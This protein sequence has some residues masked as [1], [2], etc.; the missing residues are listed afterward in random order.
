MD[1]N[2]TQAPQDETPTPAEFEEIAD[3]IEKFMLWGFNV[4]GLRRPTKILM[5]G[6]MVGELRTIKAVAEARGRV[7]GLI[8]ARDAMCP[9]CRTG[10][11]V[12]ETG[13]RW[14]PYIH[15]NHTPCWAI[16]SRMLIAQEEAARV[17]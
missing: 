11:P 5:V 1:A 7:A 12:T 14:S 13:D 10:V 9:E 17:A 3:L 2:K 6:A 16:S 4:T 15:A 8:A